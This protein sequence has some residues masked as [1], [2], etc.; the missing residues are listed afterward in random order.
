MTTLRPAVALAADRLSKTYGS[1]HALRDVSLTLP[2][3]AV[4]GLVGPN[5]AGKSTLLKCW[6]GMERPTTG[7]VMVAGRDPARNPKAVLHNTAYLAQG[8]PLYRDL[9]PSQHITLAVGWRPDFDSD[10]ATRRLAQLGIPQQ[11]R[12][13]SL[14]GGQRA[15]LALTIVTALSS[16]IL[17]LDEPLADLDPLARRSFLD[18]ALGTARGND[19]TVVLSSHIM[20]DVQYACDW[21]AVIAHGLVR[22]SAP[23][24]QVLGTHRVGVAGK[25]A[26]LAAGAL[27]GIGRK[28]EE[29]VYRIDAS[30]NVF[31][32]GQL[33]PATLEEVVFA[34]LAAPD[35][36]DAKQ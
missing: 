13:G 12:V 2:I 30:R 11:Q 17:L 3:G 32:Y 6:I 14:S 28:S 23:I 15:Q 36:R 34:Y 22:L 25:T 33:R 7:S 18:A 21:I 16:S 5:G 24:E 29:V 10:F 9:T 19:Q 20:S 1:R 31:D 35:P 27:P 26:G 8:A 4:V